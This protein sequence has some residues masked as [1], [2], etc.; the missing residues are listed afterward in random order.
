MFVNIISAIGNNSSVYPLLVRD[1]GIENVAKVTLTYKQNLKESKEIAKH[2]LRERAIDEYGTS[3]VWLGGIPLIGK[4]CDY[5][6]KRTGLS[7]YMNTKLLNETAQQGLEYNIK[8]FQDIAPESVSNLKKIKDNK[9]LFKKLA[10]A[11]FLATT[12]IP[13][14]LMGYVLPKLNFRYT[15]KKRDIE[16][17]QKAKQNTAFGKNKYFK[18]KAFKSFEIFKNN[19]NGNLKNNL[20]FKGIEALSDFTSL[21]KMMILDGGLTVGRVGT[22][23]NKAEKAEMFFKMAGMCY[24]NYVA[25]KSIEKG[26]NK[27]TKKIFNINV[28]LD[29]K[30]LADKNFVK[31]IDKLEIPNKNIL[32]Y[33]DKNPNGMFSQLAEKSGII[34]RLKNGVRN[35]EKY[36]D[37]KKLEEFKTNLFQYVKTL[38]NSNA[39]QQLAQKAFRAKSFN[40]LANIIISS[41]LLALALPKL[42]FMFRKA[43]TGSDLEPGIK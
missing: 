7:P 1:C 35:P 13:I 40:I 37:L 10:G 22:G 12:A 8:K 33:I 24:L 5:F 28:D 19:K 23:R 26:L 3:A 31:N 38:K 42:Q 6:I 16:L 18:D 36:V 39:P 11:K 9:T 32:S 27:L 15:K 2:A 34:E 43:I 21:Q 41:A 20:S 14:F 30:I 17:A 25:P 4:C 29:P